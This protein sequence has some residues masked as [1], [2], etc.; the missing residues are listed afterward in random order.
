VYRRAVPTSPPGGPTF[1]VFTPTRNRG[2]V[3]HRVYDSLAAQT[4]RDFEWL[5]VDNDSDDETPR[6]VERWQAEALLPIRY[7]RQPN[8]GLQVSWRRALDEARGELFVQTRSADALKPNALERLLAVWHEIPEAERSAFSAVSGLAED[9]H[10]N[11]IGTPF[12]SSPLDSDSSELRYRYKV[13]GDKFGFQRTDVLR[14]HLIPVVEGYTGYMPESIV[15]AAIGR[16]YRTRY[17]NERLRIYYQD[18]T[19]SLSR[20]RHPRENAVGGFI[21][22]QEILNHDLQWLRYAPL[23]FYRR[24]VKYAWSGFHTGRS[25]VEQWRRL[26]NLPARLLWLS[27]VAPGFLIFVADEVGLGGLLWRR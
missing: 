27:A 21:D 14:R 20:P 3:L 12:P 17:V 1:T 10:G 16:R 26:T 18:Q 2:H 5:V 23:A 22:A 24:A 7:F 9:E 15:W 13:T 19:T 4:F 11:L 25:A 8:R 6:L